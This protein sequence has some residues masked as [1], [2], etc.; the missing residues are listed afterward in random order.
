M[1]NEGVL[2]RRISWR[3]WV[4]ALSD[5]EFRRYYK[6]SRVDFEDLHKQLHPKLKHAYPG[7]AAGAAGGAIW[8]EVKLSMALRWMAGGNYMDV[9]LLHGVSDASFWKSV[10]V[11]LDAM[12]T[13]EGLQAKHPMLAEAVKMKQLQ[14]RKLTN[15]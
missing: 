9:Y 10:Y 2:G 11:V 13:I 8:P 15:P 14:R 7:R 1:R 5:N 12:S 6:I 3:H 4:R